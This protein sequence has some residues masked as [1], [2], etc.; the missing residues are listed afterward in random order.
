MEKYTDGLGNTFEY[1][2]EI[3][4]GGV[5]VALLNEETGEGVQLDAF[6]NI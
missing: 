1:T 2:T 3:V 5:C 6:G 4:V